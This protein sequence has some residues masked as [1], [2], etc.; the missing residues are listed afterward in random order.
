MRL[1]LRKFA[2]RIHASRSWLLVVPF[3]CENSRYFCRYST[4]NSSFE[5]GNYQHA[6]AII[7]EGAVQIKAM[8]SWSLLPNPQFGSKAPDGTSAIPAF[9]S[10][11]QLRQFPLLFFI[12]H[13][14]DYCF[15][16]L[17]FNEDCLEYATS[18]VDVYGL[19]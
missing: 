12:D 17:R 15:R 10:A 11:L 3:C 18:I 4:S 9:F 7:R 14:Q 2:C 13:D 1:K 5:P 16:V 19:G 6:Q 8:A